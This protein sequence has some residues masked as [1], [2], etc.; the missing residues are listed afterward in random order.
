M[1]KLNLPVYCKYSQKDLNIYSTTDFIIRKV[2]LAGEEIRKIHS[3]TYFSASEKYWPSFPCI[4]K[5]DN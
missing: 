5:K 4:L 3:Y 2:K 1:L